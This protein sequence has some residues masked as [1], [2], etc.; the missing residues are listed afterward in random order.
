M[1]NIKNPSSSRSMRGFI[2]TYSRLKRGKPVGFKKRGIL[3]SATV[4]PYCG[5][6]LSVK[7]T[8]CRTSLRNQ[9]TWQRRSWCGRLRLQQQEWRHQ[10]HM[11]QSH[12]TFHYGAHVC[13]TKSNKTT[14]QQGRRGLCGRRVFVLPKMWEEEEDRKKKRKESKTWP[15]PCPQ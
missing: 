10:H 8:R 15:V 13:E 3:T 4:F 6:R 7:T 9:L 12:D 14:L 1:R 5:T 2:L 11:M